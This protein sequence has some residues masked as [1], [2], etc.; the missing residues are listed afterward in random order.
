VTKGGPILMVQVKNEYG[1]F[2]NDHAYMSSTRDLIRAAGFDVALYTSDSAELKVLEGGT[3]PG[4][5]AAINFSASGDP[6][7]EFANLAKFRTDVPRMAGEFWT[8]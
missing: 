4:V 8:G 7:P 3:L 6:A 1:E 2:G 5:T